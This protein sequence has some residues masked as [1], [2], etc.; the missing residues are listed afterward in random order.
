[1]KKPK[2]GWH[3]IY[4][5]CCGKKYSK[6]THFGGKKRI[7]Y[8]EYCFGSEFPLCMKCFIKLEK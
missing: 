2:P 5:Q 8:C 7:K 4:C 6:I 3:P 1:M